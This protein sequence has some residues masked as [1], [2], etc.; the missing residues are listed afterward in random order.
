MTLEQKQYSVRQISAKHKTISNDFA[1]WAAL[2][3]SAMAWAETNYSLLYNAL[4]RKIA[5]FTT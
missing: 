4:N 5:I 1:S 2:M 3:N